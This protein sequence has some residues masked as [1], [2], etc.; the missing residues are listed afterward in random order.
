M[1]FD[2]TLLFFHAG[3]LYNFTAGEFV[4]LAAL[5]SVSTCASTV[6]NLGNA[7]DLGI[8][9]GQ[10]MPYVAV[11]IGT[12]VTSSCATLTINAQFQGSTNSTLW[13]TYA[14]TGA[15]TTASLGAGAAVFPL[16]VP[17]RPS[18]TALPLYY[19]MNLVVGVGANP[20]SVAS[21]STGTIIGGIVLARSDSGGTLDQYAS[22]FSVS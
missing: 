6:I 21:I 14:E 1:L 8:G 18:G 9:Q 11:S 5:T 16:A 4:N 17:R 10:E 19:Q 12:A 22:G 3:T 2:S 15:L 20:A 7:R 13:T